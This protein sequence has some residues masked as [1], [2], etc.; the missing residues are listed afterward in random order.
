MPMLAHFEDRPHE[1][2]RRWSPRRTLRLGLS[3]GGVQVTIH[4][5]SLTGALL[6]T[7]IVMLVGSPFTI[8]LPQAGTVPATVVWNG[9]EYYGCQFELPISPGALSAAMLQGDPGDPRDADAV[10]DPVAELRELSGEVE[11]LALR[12][13]RALKLLSRDGE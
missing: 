11:R 4:D 5:L 6:E 3:S 2:D 1:S 13:E 10:R 8:E 12:M 9:G 7:S